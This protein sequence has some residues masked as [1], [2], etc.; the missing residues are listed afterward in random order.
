[1]QLT[2]PYGKPI[3]FRP[4]MPT[5]IGNVSLRCFPEDRSV[6]ERLFTEQGTIG[7]S[8]WEGDT[9][10][11][12]LHGYRVDLP[13]G[14]SPYW[15]SWN[16]W[17]GT[18]ER[19]PEATRLV[20]TFNGKAWCIA[21][22]HVGRTLKGDSSTDRPDP[23]Y[24]GIGIAGAL[25]QATVDWAPDNGYRY[26]MAMGAPAGC[27]ELSIWWGSIPWTTYEKLGFDGVRLDGG[28]NE[29]PPW[30]DDPVPP[31]VDSERQ[32]VKVD[33]REPHEYWPRLMILKL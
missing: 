15:P 30:M 9:C 22:S 32:R 27:R 20:N 12:Q 33:G 1:M 23:A 25:L 13:S 26:V 11:G 5:D 3:E 4:I 8:A 29:L 10:V 21:C 2:S 6:I 17:W 19:T 28:L 7:A 24:F 16:K 18:V 31:E 14:H